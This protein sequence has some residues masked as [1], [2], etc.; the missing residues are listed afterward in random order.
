MADEP[1]APP[2]ELPATPDDA[3]EPAPEF[4]ADLAAET[5]VALRSHWRGFLRPQAVIVGV[6]TLILLALA[7]FG[8]ALAPYDPTSPDPVNEFLA[9]SAQHLMGTD[10]LG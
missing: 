2:P 9:P 10:D 3:L 5:P 7:I 1:A 8:P 4:L 6:V